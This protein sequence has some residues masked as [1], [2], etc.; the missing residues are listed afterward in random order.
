MKTSTKEKKSTTPK[1]SSENE[2]TAK[3]TTSTQK[4]TN[5]SS[6]QTQ[7]TMMV[8]L[9]V[10]VVLVL[11]FTS[12]SFYTISQVNDKVTRMDNFFASNAQGYD[13]GNTGNTEETGNQGAQQQQ[14]GNEPQQQQGG[15]EPQ[16]VGE[17]DISNRPVLGD[18]DA[19][20]T[21]VEYS[22]FECPFC[23]RFFQ[24]TYPQLKEQYIDT[25]KAKL[26]YKDFPLPNI[27]PM[28]EPAAIA[29]KCVYRLSDSETFF[30][31]HDTIFNNQGGLSEASLEQWATDLGVSQSEYQSCIEN[32]EVKEQVDADFN[33]GSEFGI[34][35]TPSFVIEGQLLVGAQPI[36]AFQDI[37]DAE[38]E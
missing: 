27:H 17:P 23:Q 11:I 21:I 37:I 3:K 20:V 6:Q 8:L 35:G 33:E 10:G 7:M 14:G 1:K 4:T 31:Y 15:N 29:G 19:P 2:H 24:D 22:D 5:Q 30:E 26:V 16:Q 13:S 38:L 9:L 32:P 36:S 12:F 34:S 18:E 25:G 28:A